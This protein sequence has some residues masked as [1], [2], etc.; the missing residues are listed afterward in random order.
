VVVVVQQ[1]LKKKR[2]LTMDGWRREI[3][4]KILLPPAK[5]ETTTLRSV[6]VVVVDLLRRGL[7][8]LLLLSR[9]PKKRIDQSRLIFHPAPRVTFA[10][11]WDALH[12]SLEAFGQRRRRPY[13]VSWSP[14]CRRGSSSRTRHRPPGV[15]SS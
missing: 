6:I 4:C 15:A 14:C 7:L 2:K 11:P 1:T 13:P 12:P 8:L 9:C 5:A 10:S 3:Q